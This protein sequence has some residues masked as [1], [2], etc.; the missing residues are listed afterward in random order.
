MKETKFPGEQQPNAK[1]KAKNNSNQLNE[2]M[3]EKP[4]N[5]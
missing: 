3:L 1:R 2:D 4:R 5:S